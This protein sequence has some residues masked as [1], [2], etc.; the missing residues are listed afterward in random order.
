MTGGRPGAEPPGPVFLVGGGRNLDAQAAAHAG[1]A[2]ALAG[3]AMLCLVADEGEGIDVGRWRALLAAAGVSAVEVR[4]ISERTPP[5]AS[6]L[7]GFAG[8]YVAGGL[9]PLYA[10][11][12]AS[13]A[14]SLPAGLVY[15]G[16]SAGAAV[17]ARLA[18][19]GGWRL[20]G[21]DIAPEDAA[22]DL[23]ELA[24]TPGLGLVPFAVES[25]A[26]QWGT[27]ARA[28][29][30]VAAGLVPECWALD[31]GTGLLVRDGRVAEVRGVGH[32][33]H[34]TPDADGVRLAVVPP[35]TLAG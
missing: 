7:T 23:D 31:E 3:G 10:R 30:A 1:L 25:H 32:A 8:L 28:V 24:V 13:L 5:G 2:D 4:A 15:A 27:L 33:Y 35:V 34:V 22:E 20:R 29:H 17:A 18:V 11:L 9:T 26:T 19:V 12:L 14:G 21:R 6:D 16:F